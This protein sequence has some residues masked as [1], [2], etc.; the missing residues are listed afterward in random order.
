MG[1]DLISSG[2][3][4]SSSSIGRCGYFRGSGTGGL[5]GDGSATGVS[6]CGEDKECGSEK[7]DGRSRLRCEGGT[8]DI[9]GGTIVVGAIL[10]CSDS[11][12]GGKSRASSISRA[13]LSRLCGG[14]DLV[15]VWI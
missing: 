10:S 12:A 8:A 14:G 7:R 15:P 11:R 4:G 3:K 9:G 1:G 5:G 2:T 6:S 13:W